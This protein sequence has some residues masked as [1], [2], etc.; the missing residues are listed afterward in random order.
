[1]MD[2]SRH[3]MT[4]TLP[5][6]TGYWETT[7]F[8]IGGAFRRATLDLTFTDCKQMDAV[9]KGCTHTGKHGKDS[10]AFDARRCLRPDANS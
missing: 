7:Y 1:M 3:T 2:W 5:A 10:V 8:P 6:G 4:F 9:Y